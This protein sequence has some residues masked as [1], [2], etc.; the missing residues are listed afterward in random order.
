[1]S[2]RY[3]CRSPLRAPEVV[4]LRCTWFAPA[5]FIIIIIIINKKKRKKKK[6]KKKKNCV[7]AGTT[8]LR[9]CASPVRCGR[10]EGS[11]PVLR[12]HLGP[13]GAVGY[14]RRSRARFMS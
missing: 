9:P 1:M 2:G 7:A 14:Y 5:L 11:C 6:K 13:P 10:T 8:F 3:I 4:E 12:L